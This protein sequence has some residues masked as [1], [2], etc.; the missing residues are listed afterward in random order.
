VAP[1]LP[2]RA[3]ASDFGD[4]SMEEQEERT[5]TPL[6]DSVYSQLREAI[7]EGE[8]EPGRELSEVG[9]AQRFETSRSPIREALGRLEQEGHV[10]R[11]ANGRAIVAPLDAEELSNLYEVRAW[12]E[13]LAA[14]LAAPRLTGL[15]LDQMSAHLDRMRACGLAGDIPGSLEAGGNFHD[16]VLDH[17]ANDPLREIVER[18]RAHIKRYRRVI[19]S[20]RHQNAR[21]SEHAEILD[22]LV[23]RDA[24]GAEAAMKRHILRSAE[25]FTAELKPAHSS[26]KGRD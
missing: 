12:V 8:F 26:L 15:A 9:L 1:G 16:V 6:R 21:A 4:I 7:L 22:A 24:D 18:L 19:A 20:N 17:C 2:D 13:G 25:W 3:Q 10:L 23:R 11:K 14:R 5:R